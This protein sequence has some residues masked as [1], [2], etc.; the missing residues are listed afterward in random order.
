MLLSNEYIVKIYICKYY[1][2]GSILFSVYC[3]PNLSLILFFQGSGVNVLNKIMVPIR[4]QEWL[5]CFS[6]EV[7]VFLKLFNKL[8]LIGLCLFNQASEAAIKK[9]SKRSKIGRSFANSVRALLSVPG[10]LFATAMS[11]KLL[12]GVVAAFLG[13][14]KLSAIKAAKLSQMLERRHELVAVA[15]LQLSLSNSTHSATE[16]IDQKNR[17]QK[18]S[19][20]QC[21][22][23][24]TLSGLLQF[25]K[26]S[27]LFFDSKKIQD[28]KFQLRE[29]VNSVSDQV[30]K[31]SR[32]CKL[33]DDV[34][35][36]T[37]MFDQYGSRRQVEKTY[38]QKYVDD[39]KADD[40][41]FG[42][43][44]Q[45]VVAACLHSYLCKVSHEFMS[46][47]KTEDSDTAGVGT[48]LNLGEF[49]GGC[50]GTYSDL[51][52]Q[53]IRQNPKASYL[54]CGRAWINIAKA[55]ELL[56]AAQL[57]FARLEA[58]VAKGAFKGVEI[59]M[60]GRDVDFGQFLLDSHK[61]KLVDM[62]NNLKFARDLT[63]RA[64]S[65]LESIHGKDYRP[66]FL[67]A[68]AQER[69]ATADS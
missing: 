67:P 60:S 20:L 6:I 46:L 45:K 47:V 23:G 34:G 31:T 51:D 7:F 69:L 43:S 42:D 56:G 48:L 4:S 39:L 15:K 9:E 49:G 11:H 33:P 44:C 8:L 40:S 62:R 63:L 32:H 68:P 54:G 13:Y 53:F 5:I 18:F 35:L 65:A 19:D 64:Q 55:E 14:N 38:L 57:A 12:I 52:F 22:S 66:D 26:Q 1:D 36:E 41:N 21:S 24:D 28:P 17:L 30:L 2:F 61:E 27:C 37:R 50:G 59:R 10:R 16:D 25:I 58:I 29:L 3:L